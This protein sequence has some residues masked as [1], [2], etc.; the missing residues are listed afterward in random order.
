MLSAYH[1]PEL[2][3]ALGNQWSDKANRVPTLNRAWSLAKEADFK[4][5]NLSYDFLTVQKL[6]FRK[7]QR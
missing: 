2:L 7:L 4:G 5:I 6:G 3:W 1:V